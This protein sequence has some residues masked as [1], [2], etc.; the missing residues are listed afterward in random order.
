[1]TKQ[2]TGEQIETVAYHI[3]NTDYWLSLEHRLY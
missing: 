3:K 1:M 2:K